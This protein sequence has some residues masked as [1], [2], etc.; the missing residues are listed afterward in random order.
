MWTL[1]ASNYLLPLLLGKETQTE[2]E[3]EEIQAKIEILRNVVSGL[4][5]LTTDQNRLATAQIINT[6]TS[7]IRML[8]K[9]EKKDKVQQSLGLAV[10]QW[11]RENTLLALE[12]KK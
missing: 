9:D 12:K 4:N 3:E 2:Q 5:D 1:L 7:R 8:R 6:Y 11:E 10:L